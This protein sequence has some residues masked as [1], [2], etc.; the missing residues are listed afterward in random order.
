MLRLGD[1]TEESHNR[2]QTALND[3]WMYTGESFKMD[4]VDQQLLERGIAADL[5]SLKPKWKEKVSDIIKEATLI[6]P[7][8]SIFMVSGSR[9]GN[10]TEHFGHL[11]TE[12]QILPRSLPDAKW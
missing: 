5:Q 8:D 12:M 9:R 1:G 6:L 10:H 11:L 3:I 4:D 2:I 7:D